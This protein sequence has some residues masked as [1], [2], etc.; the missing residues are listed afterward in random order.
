MSLENEWIDAPDNEEQWGP[1]IYCDPESSEIPTYRGNRVQVEFYNGQIP[2]I[3]DA[4]EWGWGG[5]G[6]YSIRNYRVRHV[7]PWVE[8]SDNQMMCPCDENHYVEV[9][10]LDGHLNPNMA[11]ADWYSWDLSPERTARIVKFRHVS[12]EYHD[13]HSI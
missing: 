1:W 2:G 9:K 7:G 8:V 11:R 6:D 12:K 3:K 10:L 4:E 5:T 13:K